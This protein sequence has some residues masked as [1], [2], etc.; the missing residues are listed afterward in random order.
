MNSS[1]SPTHPRGESAKIENR[2]TDGSS[3][4]GRTVI[5]LG[6]SGFFGMHLARFFSADP[7]YVR[8]ILA[9]INE[10]RELVPGA[11]W[12]YCDI[13]QPI[14][15]QL[16]GEIEI[17]NLAAVHTT[18]GHEDWEYYWTNI[19]GAINACRF[20]TSCGARLV[21]FTS[22]MMVYGYNEALVDESS[23]PSPTNAYGRSKLLAEDIHRD[24]QRT[25]RSNRLI[26]VRPAVVFGEGEG[27]NFT[28]LAGLI[29]R[30]LFIYPGRTDTIKAC[31][32]VEDL[33]RCIDFIS[34][35]DEPTI[36]FNYA[37]PER[38]TSK[39][40]ATSLATAAGYPLPRLVAPLWLM[41]SAGYLFEL[42]ATLG[43]RTGI[44]RDRIRKLAN[45]TNVYPGVLMSRRWTFRYGL[46]EA[47]RRWN[48]RSNFR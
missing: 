26:V 36:T 15:I 18:P 33:G 22:T 46:I 12:T 39:V 27:G 23:Q 20:A 8:I 47:L 24:W 14:D 7:R 42:L 4:S 17:Y 30:G 40:I 21:V 31:A 9:D 43:L 19:R 29:R 32:P 10:P 3:T 1:L 34:S 16:S 44:H 13:R 41:M 38:T 5:L 6:G 28:R 45:S 35:Q 2:H 25:S 11:E 48:D 37:F